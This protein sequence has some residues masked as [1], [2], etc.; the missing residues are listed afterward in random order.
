MSETSLNDTPQ[1]GNS[2][3]L[4]E[5]PLQATPFIPP[6]DNIKADFNARELEASVLEWAGGKE[7][8][9]VTD[10]FVKFR[11]K[12]GDILAAISG[13][14][15]KWDDCQ[16]DISRSVPVGSRCGWALGDWHCMLL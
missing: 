15:G 16:N 2:S 7:D 8:T 11:D 5:F 13:D 6:I 9:A 4:F 12:E 1:D 3:L 10:C 14:G